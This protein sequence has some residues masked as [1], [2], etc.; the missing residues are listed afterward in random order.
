M[1][2]WSCPDR[3]AILDTRLPSHRVLILNTRWAISKER[4]VAPKRAQIR[5]DLLHP[6]GYPPR[7]SK[8][9]TARS[10][11]HTRELADILSVS[12]VGESV[13]GK[14]PFTIRR[15]K[16]RFG[17][18]FPQKLIIYLRILDILSLNSHRKSK[19]TPLW[20]LI[21]NLFTEINDPS[22]NRTKKWQNI[23]LAM[24]GLHF[25]YRNQYPSS[26]RTK[27][28]RF[29]TLETKGLHF[30]YRI[31]HISHLIRYKI[32]KISGMKLKINA[33]KG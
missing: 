32:A 15:K 13:P 26:N 14:Y 3:V 18:V 20:K 23:P 16:D 6:H 10:W 21:Y 27:K 24:K 8:R 17:E 19:S 7:A 33:K 25:V 9:H 4:K 28:R 2:L 11:G 22:S 5:P 1:S 30:V 29:S 12:Y 31:Q